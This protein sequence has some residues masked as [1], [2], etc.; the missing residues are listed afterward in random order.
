MPLRMKPLV[1]V[2]YLREILIYDPDTGL[3][4]WRVKKCNRL[5]IG[6]PAGSL[7]KNGYRSISI[8]AQLYREHRLAW[9]YVTGREPLVEVDHV[10]GVKDDNRWTNLRQADRQQNTKNN[11]V[12]MDSTSG[13]TGVSWIE[14][15]Q[16]YV[17][18]ITVNKQYYL[19]G[20][21]GNFEDAVAAR[22]AAEKL[23]FGEFRRNRNA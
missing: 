1:D 8:D 2:S 20:R 16:N 18:Q 9:L 10:N 19:L 6:A 13:V 11:S 17:A 23:Y 21:F 12:R 15:S 4:T 22:R 5:P 7:Q 3:F 14:R